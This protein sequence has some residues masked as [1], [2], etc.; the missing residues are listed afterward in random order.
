MPA[1][2]IHELPDA[3]VARPGPRPA[4]R[5]DVHGQAHL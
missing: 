4:R 2:E 1:I 3:D 5:H